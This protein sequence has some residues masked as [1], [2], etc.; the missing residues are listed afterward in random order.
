MCT[1][2]LL[3]LWIFKSLLWVEYTA[4]PKNMI[5]EDN[6]SCFWKKCWKFELCRQQNV[7]DSLLRA[8]FWYWL[9][10][11]VVEWWVTLV[12]LWHPVTC[13]QGSSV[14]LSAARSVSVQ[15]FL[16]LKAV[17]KSGS[18]ETRGHLG[19]SPLW[20]HVP[21][22]G[23]T[24]IPLKTSSHRV[25]DQNNEG[26]G[27]CRFRLFSEHFSSDSAEFFAL[28]SFKLVRC[29]ARAKKEL[30]FDF[31]MCDLSA[32]SVVSNKAEKNSFYCQCL[33]GSK[34]CCPSM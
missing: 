25:F 15:F 16:L 9:A 12:I 19:V 4:T 14:G 27:N 10:K 8:T 21:G 33:W 13:L 34:P 18:N 3:N 32:E 22:D 28:F 24:D 26:Q 11:L 7:S 20:S 2:F 1:L 6:C 29:T 17:F 31:L 5:F 30:R 23:K